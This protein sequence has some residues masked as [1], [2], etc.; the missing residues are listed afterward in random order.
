MSHAMLL[1]ALETGAILV[2]RAR[3]G[4]QCHRLK[5]GSCARRPSAAQRCR[6]AG[7]SQ[8]RDACAVHASSSKF[9]SIRS[10]SWRDW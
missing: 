7:T 4:P 3:V 10:A 1:E 8:R 6:R 5:A 9:A 2:G